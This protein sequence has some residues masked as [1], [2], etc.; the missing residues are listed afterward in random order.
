[1][2]AIDGEQEKSLRAGSDSRQPIN[3]LTKT[4]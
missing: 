2:P 3:G 4:A 1:V